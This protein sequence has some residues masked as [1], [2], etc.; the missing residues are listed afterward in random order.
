MSLGVRMQR[1]RAWTL[2]IFVCVCSATLSRATAQVSVH[3]N[4]R[5]SAYESISG[6]RIQLSRAAELIATTTSSASG[7]YSLSVAPDVYDLT[8]QP[9]PGSPFGLYGAYKLSLSTDLDLE[10]AFGKAPEPQLASTPAQESP[11]TPRF[12]DVERVSYSG[13]VVD[14]AGAAVGGVKVSL[15]SDGVYETHADANGAFEVRGAPLTSSVAVSCGDMELCPSDTDHSRWMFVSYPQVDLSCGP[16]SAQQL[17]VQ[18][19]KLIGTVKE[20]CGGPLAG[21]TVSWDEWD[22]H[23]GNGI[24]GTISDHVLTDEQGRFEI[25]VLPGAGQLTASFVGRQDYTQT[26]MYVTVPETNADPAPVPLELWPVPPVEMVKSYGRVVDSRGRGLA[27]ARVRL[28]GRDHSAF[29]DE[30]GAFELESPRGSS[31]LEVYY[32]GQQ[33]CNGEGDPRHIDLKWPAGAFGAAPLDGVEIVIDTR[34]ISGAVVDSDGIFLTK[35]RLSWSQ[36]FVSFDDHM[37][38][39]ELGDSVGLD[40][41]TFTLLAIAGSEPHIPGNLN[42]FAGDDIHTYNALQADHIVSDDFSYVI[43]LQIPIDTA[44]AQ[45]E[46]GGS[47]STAAADGGA[48]LEDPIET[49]VWSPKGGEASIHEHPLATQAPNGFTYMTQEIAVSAPDASTSDPLTIS[50]RLDASRLRENESIDRLTV[51]HEGVRV[52]S[53][54]SVPSPDPCL[55]QRQR[56]DDADVQ[57][58]VKT[59]HAGVWNVGM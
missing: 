46:A 22:V 10:L 17:V 20:G 48:T 30:S 33:R 24:S 12:A 53:C 55:S 42:V 35:P 11:T 5:G 16:L 39:G 29:T 28:G 27:Y 25:T 58:T 54:D 26:A 41:G 13:R 31:R 19:R 44:T 40:G 38:E 23:Y 32:C 34:T 7:A 37:P 2:G 8:V 51:F 56:L 36:Q 18:N 4:V 15:F 6:A 3:G 9:A 45:L 49:S 47:L 59:T 52:L 21:V 1:A 43:V 57:L 14:R 50:F